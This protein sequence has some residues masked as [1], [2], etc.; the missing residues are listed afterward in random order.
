MTFQKAISMINT[1][2]KSVCFMKH[3]C[4]F[5]LT[6]KRFNVIVKC[7]DLE[8]VLLLL[9]FSPCT[10]FFSIGERVAACSYRPVFMF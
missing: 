8:L 4:T 5:I 3:W 7:N 9:I 6:V 2:K 10:F 1:G